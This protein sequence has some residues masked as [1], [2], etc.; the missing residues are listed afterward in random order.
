MR[1]QPAKIRVVKVGG[2]LL[3]W[4]GLPAALRQWLANEEAALNVLLC[5]GGRLVDEIR[6]AQRLYSLGDEEAH[7]LAIECLTVT[8]RL[9]AT[10]CRFDLVREYAQ[11]RRAV[12]GAEESAIVVDPHGF[13]VSH[14]AT[15]PGRPLPHDWTA[16]SDSIA[17]RLAECVHAAELVLLKSNDPPAHDPSAL[18][19]AGY[20]DENFAR[21][22]AGLPVVRLVNL[23]STT[24]AAQ[25]IVR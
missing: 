4:P 5:G 24:S 7:W 25:F 21:S 16:T 12:R 1:D 17:V 18:V 11:V 15:L 9:L 6:E 23:R 13:L 3:D 19:A 2:S 10:I 14:E 8:A 20:V 22:V